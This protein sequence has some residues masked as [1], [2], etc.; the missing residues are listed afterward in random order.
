MKARD[1]E[2]KVLVDADACPVKGLIVE[3][4]KEYHLPVIFYIDTSHIL[5]DDYAE[6]MTVGQGRDAVDFA[7]VNHTRQGDIVV[8]Q[9]YGLAAMAVLKNARAIHPSGLVYTKDNLDRLLFE[10][11]MNAKIR[12]AGG[13]HS[14]P[15]KRKQSDNARFERAFRSLCASD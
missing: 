15:R 12:R 13:R 10:R 6:V 9:D 7:L 11:H 2:R 3:V 4:A 1:T 5:E 14:G 8:T